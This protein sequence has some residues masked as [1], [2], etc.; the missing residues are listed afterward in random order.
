MGVVLSLL[1]NSLLFAATLVLS[2]SA[3]TPGDEGA[4]GPAVAFPFAVA[5]PFAVAV[6]VEDDVAVVA[7]PFTLDMILC[8]FELPPF[9]VGL[10]AVYSDV[11]GWTGDV[12]DEMS[13]GG[14][15][16]AA[17]APAAAVTLTCVGVP[18]DADAAATFCLVGVSAPELHR[19]D[20]DEPEVRWW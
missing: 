16:F 7:A 14:G 1:C 4:D 12:G 10:V 20:E 17:A 5:L 19:L 9:K 2:A 18:A 11:L 15:R 3:P 13:V 6:A 8:C